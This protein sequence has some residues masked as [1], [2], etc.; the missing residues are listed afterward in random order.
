LAACGGNDVEP[1]EDGNTRLRYFLGVAPS[2]GSTPWYVALEEGFYADAGLDVEFVPGESTSLGPALIEDGQADMASMD[3]TSLAL[4][5]V[6]EPDLPIRMVA[7]YHARAFHAVYSLKSGANIE[8]PEDLEGVTLYTRVG[9]TSGKII[10]AWGETIGVNDIKLEEADPDATDRLLIAG[11]APALSSTVFS[12]PPLDAAAEQ[13]GEEIAILELADHGLDPFY[14][15]GITASEEFMENEP[16]AVRAFVDAS[17]RAFE[18]CFENPEEAAEIM[19]EILP[20]ITP[21][22]VPPSLAALEKVVSDN[23]TVERLG[24]IDPETV[25]ATITWVEDAFG[26]DIDPESLYTTEFRQ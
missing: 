6:E 10:Q 5:K 18:W 1:S 15:I 20:T 3:L 13:A 23:G 7:V 21:E 19:A 2:T 22:S 11:R 9:G 14:G 24:V 12:R 25:A 8:E 4:A 26:V 16:E 17:M